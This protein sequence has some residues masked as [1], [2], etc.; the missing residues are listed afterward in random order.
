MIKQFGLK[1]FKCHE[2]NN[3][4]D[5]PGMSIVTGT[6]NSGKSSLLQSIYLLTQNRTKNYPV[7]A[8]NEE[9]KLGGFSDVLNKSKSSSESI[10]ITI[11]FEDYLI[12]TEG[13]KELNVTFVYNSPSVLQKFSVSY[14]EENPILFEININY[15][16][17]MNSENNTLQFRIVDEKIDSLIY[18]VTGLF[19]NGYCKIGGI[20]P[21]PIIYEEIDKTNKT[22]CSTD[23]D[24]IR[25]YLEMLN[26]EN[27]KYIRAFRLDDFA[28]K[29]NSVNSSLG[30]SGEYTAE[31]INTK[32]DNIVDFL[33]ESGKPFIF[34]KLFDYWI[35]QLLGDN[36]RIRS[37]SIDKGKY[38]IVIQEPDLGY[39]FTLNQVGFGI[40]QLLPIITL[41]LTSKKGD[42]IL[43]ENP[44]VHLHPKLQAMFIDLCLFVLKNKRK[45]II[46]THSEHIINRLRVRIK[47]DQELL[48]YVNIFFFEKK[49]GN[50][51]SQ[52][53][54]I[55]KEGKL[56]YWPPNFFD[57]TYNDLL[58]LIE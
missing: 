51:I 28:D 30:L 44:E 6:N 55:T 45:L 32:W 1:D 52:K 10:E 46:E 54:E 14:L 22:M 56:E 47:G 33:D 25:T 29:N 34:S 53:I 3:Y 41:L 18:K 23:F 26:N 38:K 50:I 15:S 16:K 57:Q 58:G 42:M 27:I 39:E 40:S 5:L 2:D 43:V 9:L 35:L 24:V 11:E 20:V 37:Y 36:Y 49:G 17:N 31:V 13:L 19:D 12:E 8:L 4:F 7:L 21:E 48:S